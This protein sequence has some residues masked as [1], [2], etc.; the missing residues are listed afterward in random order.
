MALNHLDQYFKFKSEGKH[1]SA[2]TILNKWSPKGF[3]EA[4]YKKYFLAVNDN[5]TTEFWGLYQD[6]S[7]NKKLLKLQH[8]SIRRILEI[9]LE[10]KKDTT[11]KLKNFNKVAKQ[12]LENLRA[13]PEG[14]EY[15]LIYL[16]WILKNKNI[17]E[18]CKTERNRWL[19]QTT[20]NLSEVVLGLQSCPITYKDFIYRLRMLIFSGE[21]KKAQA[22]INEFVDKQKL[23]EW[24]KAYLQA[25]YFSNI[26]D[27]TSAFNKVIS[28]QSDIAKNPD[29]YVNL[30]YISQRAGELAKAEQIINQVIDSSV[31][32]KQK[33][34]LLFQKAFLFYQTRRYSEALKILNSLVVTHASHHRKVKS[35]EYDDL[36]WLRAWCYYLA[37]DFEKAQEA[38]ME[39]RKWARD[40]A[41]NLYW[42]AQ[43]EWALDNRMMSV[44]LFRQLALPV[45]D[46]KFFSY[47][48]YIAWLRFEA[49]KAYATSEMLKT[50]LSAIK[51]RREM[52]MIADPNM[53]PL[54][55]LNE[56]ESYFEDIGLTD[57]GSIAI[58][59]QEE[60]THDAGEIK[61]IKIKTS[62]ELK[63][64]MS[65][66][67]DLIRWGY[68]DLAKWH[69]F[70]VEKTL[71]TKSEAEPLVKYYTDNKYYNRAL[72]LTQNVLSPSGR[73]LSFKSD[74]LLWGSL[75]PKA[76]Q[77]SVE[78]EAKKRKVHTHLIWSIM[79]AET[80]YKYD[81]I[82]PVGAVGLMQFMPY[83]SQ[84]VAIML[85][86]E[87][88]TENM[89]D[90]ETAIKYGATYLRKLSDELGGEFPLV[91][92]AYNGGP[93]RVKL[94]M[95][96][97]KEKD[98]T[99]MEY[100]MFVEHIPFNETRTYVKRVMSF[101]LTY[102]KLYED[103]LDYKSS[104]WLV[105][106]IPFKLKEPIVLKEEWPFDKK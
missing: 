54:E 2:R 61:G 19:S 64:E 44:A 32:A 11:K 74:P 100:D 12:M 21:E 90:P 98:G 10:S 7:K 16:K 28:Y 87:H 102:Q 73:T 1:K 43:T 70:E 50:Q 83:T 42:L 33:K 35:R 104:K 31:N 85:K 15:E 89:F 67:D 62:A 20:L 6:L 71:S 36:T 39:N 84:K 23:A 25:V 49:Y 99:N 79:K 46:G 106:K 34:E 24:E 72:S 103:K 37:G 60:Q 66:A 56:Y 57:E 38:L 55:L 95:R 8:E 53:N 101:V 41:R 17:A 94:W 59:N 80:Q 68:R 40:K 30:F 52:Y 63:N 86:E 48:N 9:D 96:N 18:L 27:P 13:Q 97:F 4:S 82:S 22:E 92:A 105:E 91:A 88:N 78:S 69:L 3:E 5:T 77:S 14:L 81:A 58:I 93:H 51:S 65:W 47:Y 75:F 76:Y 29:Y 45:I 26:G